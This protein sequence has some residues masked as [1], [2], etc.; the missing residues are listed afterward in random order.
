MELSQAD[1]NVI[2]LYVFIEFLTKNEALESYQEYCAY[3]IY[4]IMRDMTGEFT[5]D[6]YTFLQEGFSWGGTKEGVEYWSTLDD[7]WHDLYNKLR[8][9]LN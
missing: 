9:K 7:K 8:L 5:L 1:K 3:P 2:I 6:K 4:C